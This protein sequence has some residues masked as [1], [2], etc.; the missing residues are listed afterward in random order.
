MVKMGPE[1]A[2]L[3]LSRRI[4]S[5][6][7]V[8]GIS[9]EDLGEMLGISFQQVQKYEK[10]INKLSFGKIVRL[11]HAL[12]TT[13]E[14]L[15]HGLDDAKTTQKVLAVGSLI[16]GKAH[17]ISEFYSRIKNADLR[18]TIYNLVEQLSKADDEHA[19]P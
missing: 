13:F 15:T 6:R 2:D 5:Q 14:V 16:D 1:P 12:D 17:R 19:N 11:A 4:R 9:Q 18:N 3:A 7:L 10:G 8:V